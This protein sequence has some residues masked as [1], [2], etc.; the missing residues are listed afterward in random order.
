MDKKF[1]KS[2]IA[3]HGRGRNA[4]NQIPVNPPIVQSTNFLYS[5]TK[6]LRD[7][8]EGDKSKFENS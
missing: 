7:Y 5:N 2:T 3:V 8:Q 1:K 4:L 6:Q